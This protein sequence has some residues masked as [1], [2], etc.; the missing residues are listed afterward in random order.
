M[1]EEDLPVVEAAARATG[2]EGAQLTR[3]GTLPAV[4]Q[5]GGLIP[6]RA[7]GDGAN[8]LVPSDVVPPVCPYHKALLEREE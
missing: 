1:P 8:W 4:A 5:S 7:P 2:G 6:P 3:P